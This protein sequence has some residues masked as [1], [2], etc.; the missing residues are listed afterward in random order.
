MMNRENKA[1]KT[2]L[3]FINVSENRHIDVPGNTGTST[4]A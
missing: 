3:Y 2:S 4:R 1:Q